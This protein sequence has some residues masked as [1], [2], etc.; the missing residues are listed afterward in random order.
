[1][2]IGLY[3]SFDPVWVY[4]ILRLSIPGV[5]Y[6]SVEPQFSSIIKVRGNRTRKNIITEVRRHYLELERKAGVEYFSSNYLHTLSIEY[7][8]ETIKPI[9]LFTLICKS[10]IVKSIQEKINLRYLHCPKVD[11]DALLNAAIQKFGDRIVITRAVRNYLSILE[12]FGVIKSLDND[13][14]EIQNTKSNCPTYVI[15]DMIL[16]YGLYNCKI[17]IHLDE[18]LSDVSFTYVNLI[19]IED[20]LREFNSKDWSYQKRID[21]SILYIRKQLNKR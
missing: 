20:V 16:L 13:E 11:I 3:E 6:S 21:S 17:E 8:Y 4:K 12:N 5:K 10:G 1:M 9:L 15:K 14:F 19:E 18:L 7:S 2:L